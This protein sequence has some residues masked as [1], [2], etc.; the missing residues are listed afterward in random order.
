MALLVK[1]PNIQKFAPSNGGACTKPRMP[2]Q[3]H[4]LA[5]ADLYRFMQNQEAIRKQ[6][7]PIAIG[8]HR[9]NGSEG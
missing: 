8:V 3:S 6:F 9:L 1:K 5:L 4:R 7:Q 2:V